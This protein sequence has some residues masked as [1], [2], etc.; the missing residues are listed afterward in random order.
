MRTLT[1][2]FAP[3]AS[4]LPEGLRTL[5]VSP[6][7]FVEPGMTVRATFAFYNM[8][9]APATGLRVRFN[10]PEGLRYLVGS[11]QVDGVPLDERDGE[12]ALLS[13]NGA[14]I[15]EVPPVGERRI[16]LSYLVAPTIEN[17]TVIELQAALASLEIPVIGSNIVRLV[18]RSAPELQNAA[19]G[20]SLEPVREARPGEEI[21]IAARVF[22]AGQSSAHDVI[23]VLPIPDHTTYVPGSARIDGREVAVDERGDPF[24]FAHAPVA[25][26][27]LGAGAAV[28]VEYRARIAVPLENGTVLAVDGAVASAETPEFPLPRAELVVESKSRFDGEETALVVSGE[29]E[30]EP[31][32]RIRIAL[33][34]KNTGT[35]DARQVS[36][37]IEL[38]PELRYAAGSRT[39][40]LRPIGEAPE[41][42]LYTFDRIAAGQRIEAALEAYAITPGRDGT[43]L[44]LRAT[45]TWS[46]GSRTLERALTLRARPRFLEGRNRIEVPRGSLSPGEPLSIVVH[47]VNDG[48]TRATG[49]R[50]SLSCDDALQDRR[51][52][53]DDGEE[54]ELSAEPIDLG[55]LEPLEPRTITLHARVASPLADRTELRV[56]ASLSTAELE[57]AWRGSVTLVVRSRPRF[58]PTGSRLMRLGTEPL[59]PDRATD[60]RVRI[61]NEGSDVARD[62]RLALRISPEARIEAVDGASRDGATL[63]FG[64]VD[65]GAVAEATVRIRLERFVD[66]G[67]VI[68]VDGRLSGVGFL[69]FGL[70]PV[71]ITTEAT[72][73]FRDGA[74]LRTQPAETVESG[75]PVSFS[76][77]LRNTG[78]GSARKLTIAVPPVANTVYI[79]GSTSVNEVA[80]L[81][82]DGGSLLWHHD[83]L[84]L[85]DIAPG[86]EVIVRWAAIVNTPLPLGTVIEAQAQLAWDGGARHVV[87]AQPLRV[88]SMPAFAVRANGLPFNVSGVAAPESA[89]DPASGASRART[90]TSA[91]T[92]SPAIAALPRA[93]PIRPEQSANI[94]D[95]EFVDAGSESIPLVPTPSVS[96]PTVVLELPEERLGRTLRYLEQVD[97]Q[98][99]ITHVF[100]LRALFPDA[101]VGVDEPVQRK[102]DAL[103]ESLRA[104]L[105]RLFIKLRLPRYALTSKDLEDGATRTALQALLDAIASSG[106]HR[107][108]LPPSPNLRI[109][110]TLDLADL[111]AKSSSL[112]GAPLGSVAPWLA[113]VPLIGST[114]EQ[115]SNTSDAVGR[116]AEALANALTRV[117]PLPL[118][119][120]HR[121]LTSSAN[122]AL[123]EA[124]HDVVRVLRRSLEMQMSVG[125]RA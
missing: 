121:V 78:D 95:A 17:G 11:A 94:S 103:R 88:R 38:P 3:G 123:D 106:V 92:A 62:V 6:E 116:Y 22:N 124:L 36:A 45:L 119:E 35:C 104:T 53:L 21:R 15:G 28:L 54:D 49:A 77:M 99:L 59:R 32:E 19:T 112:E 66:H 5:V 113:L 64:D 29:T 114:I 9:G 100:A 4:P 16:S 58:T 13:I 84:V 27:T 98:G 8:G 111:A 97:F 26:T 86:V 87:E 24:G 108:A 61:E 55:T 20:V 83:G 117:A 69:T 72:P 50:L 68:S 46:T 105:D 65:A 60:V 63:I 52:R 75:A 107:A 51:Y 48:T 30:I 56:V 79:P 73:E 74:V 89:V 76:L 110:G 85:E 57:H 101:I 37:R 118:G 122:A 125:D 34:A 109:V 33:V 12:T 120:F 70:Y 1:E 67:S 71:T 41:P 25:A 90:G 18:A 115:G 42:G 7:R 2:V 93:V 39:I 91:I 40:D 43:H 44:P 96:A 14:D 81:D 10:L 23:A 47:V 102:L 82:V 80:L 31:G